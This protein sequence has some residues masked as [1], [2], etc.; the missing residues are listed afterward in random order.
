MIKSRVKVPPKRKKRE[1][2][3]T[4]RQKAAKRT[5]QSILQAARNVF[6]TRGY[7]G[8]TMPA[9]AE[10]AGVALDTVYASFGKKPALFRLLIELAISGAEEAVPAE[11]RDYVRAIRSESDALKKLQIYAGAVRAIQERLAPLFEVLRAAAPLD[12]ELAEL[13]HVISQ[14][15]A[16]NMRLLA[17]ELAGT[18]RLR[19]DV[20]IDKA[21]DILWSMNSPELFV[22]LVHERGW[23]SRDF[24]QW[25]GDAWVRLLLDAAP[26]V[27]AS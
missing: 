3:A 16:Q 12:A 5:K 6:L 2:D 9:I 19:A 27:P 25:L 8:A 24:E 4:S 1:Y 15:R 17:A 18:G 22:L 23:P 26:R 21:A 14:R 13:W 11:E 20:S 10:A 7:A